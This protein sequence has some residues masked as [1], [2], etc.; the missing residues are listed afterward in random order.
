M[1]LYYVKTRLGNEL[2]DAKTLEEA[3][4]IVRDD[5]ANCGEMKLSVVIFRKIGLK[6]YV[7]DTDYN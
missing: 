6:E 1:K 5:Y 2:I 3:K 7:I 4:S